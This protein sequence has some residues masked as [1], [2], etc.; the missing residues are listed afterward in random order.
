[1]HLPPDAQCL[2]LAQPAPAGAAA[3]VAQLLRQV[4][5]AQPVA[6]D[7]QDAGQGRSMRYSR[8]A[9]MAGAGLRR[10]EGLDSFPRIV[11][12]EVIRG[13]PAAYTTEYPARKNGSLIP[14]LSLAVWFGAMVPTPAPRRWAGSGECGQHPTRTTAV[15]AIT[16]DAEALT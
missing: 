6:Q 10:Q 5:P 3:A 4:A 13:H 1:M 2:P 14:R 11:T 12:D 7:V 8:R 15:R 16:F 9:A